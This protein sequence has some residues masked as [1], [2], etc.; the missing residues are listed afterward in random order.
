[1][2]NISDEKARLTTDFFCQTSRQQA[3]DQLI[4]LTLYKYEEVYKKQDY[5]VDLKD[6]LCGVQDKR[7]KVPATWYPHK[8]TNNFWAWWQ[9]IL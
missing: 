7:C 2:E 6:P 4:D 9:R 8:G 3:S 1:M 5:V